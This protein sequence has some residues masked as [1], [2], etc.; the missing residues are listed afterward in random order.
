MD[1]LQAGGRLVGE[2]RTH[3]VAVEGEG[4]TGRQLENLPGELPAELGEVRYPAL[5]HSGSL[6]RQFHRNRIDPRGGAD[7][8]PVGGGIAARVVEAEDE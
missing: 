7:P 6:A 8:A 5:P 3:R 2:G 1:L 4:R